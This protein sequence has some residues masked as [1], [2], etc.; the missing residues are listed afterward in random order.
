MGPAWTVEGV[1]AVLLR[2]EGRVFTVQ[3]D[4]ASAGYGANWVMNQ[5]VYFSGIG[6]FGEA[7]LN[8]DIATG[9]ST[10]AA[11]QYSNAN[12][13]ILLYVSFTPDTVQASVSSVMSYDPLTMEHRCQN[14]DPV[15]IPLLAVAQRYQINS[16]KPP[17]VIR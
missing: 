14:G 1:D 5:P 3:V 10:A 9:M 2:F 13:D 11:V 17:F 6:C 7:Y 8:R 4:R 15:T 16:Y 12:Q